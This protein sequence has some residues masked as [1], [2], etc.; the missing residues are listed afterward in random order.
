MIYIYIKSKWNRCETSFPPIENRNEF[1]RERRGKDYFIDRSLIR[2]LETRLGLT[3]G[4][5]RSTQFPAVF[6]GCSGSPIERA[7]LVIAVIVYTN[8]REIKRVFTGHAATIST[9]VARICSCFPD[10]GNSNLRRIVS[11]PTEK[12]KRICRVSRGCRE[13]W[14][15]FGEIPLGRRE[16]CVYAFAIRSSLQDQM[17]RSN[18]SPYTRSLYVIL[19][20]IGVLAYRM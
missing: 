15:K 12:N 17:F 7:L 4:D 16:S 8:N 3:R 20:M 19:R 11:R 6:P 2:N 18:S 5:Q 1:Y 9:R 14:T 10:S 13:D